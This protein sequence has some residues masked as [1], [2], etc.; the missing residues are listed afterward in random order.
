MSINTNFIF[1]KKGFPPPFIWKIEPLLI[2][3]E[4]SEVRYKICLYVSAC[5]WGTAPCTYKQQKSDN[6]VCTQLEA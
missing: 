5:N 2:L 6:F 1:N 3:F 4:G